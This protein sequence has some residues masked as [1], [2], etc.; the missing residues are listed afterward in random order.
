MSSAP[1][2]FLA[3]LRRNL[4]LVTALAIAVLYAAVAGPLH[5]RIELT[6]VVFAPL[7][8]LLAG[9][10]L[11]RLRFD[12]VTTAIYLGGLILYFF[13]LGY[14]TP[15]ERNYD[16]PEQI[17]YLK[18]IAEKHAIPPA[19]HC[20]IC[21]HPPFYY[22]L[23]AFAYQFFLTTKLAPHPLGIQ[24]FSLAIF[25][26]F[27]VYGGLFVRLYARDRRVVRIATALLV[28]WPYSIHNSVR[29]HNDTL[30]AALVAAGMYYAGRWYKGERPRH[31]YLAALCG[32]LGILTKSTAYVLVAA[33]GLMLVWKFFTRPG[34][35]RL[36]RRGVTAM[37]LVFAAMGALAL[38]AP[39]G[40][41]RC[42][43]TLGT[44]CD[45]RPRDFVGNGPV[46]YLYVDVRKL[47]RDPYMVIANDESGRQYFWNHVLKSSLFG[48][49]NK[50]PDRET[51]YQLN[52][53]LGWWL[54]VSLFA[55]LVYAAVA[56]VLGARRGLRHHGVPLLFVVLSSAFLMAFRVIIPAPHHTDFRHIFFAIVPGVLLFAA[57]VDHLRARHKAL[58]AVGYVLFAPFV[59]LSILYFVPKYDLVMKYTHTTIDVSLASV[60]KIVNEG[61]SW[62]K[63][64]NLLIEG[65]QTI[66]L[67]VDRPVT[68]T[69][70]ETS[71]DG[72]DSY[73]LKLFG[74]GPPRVMVVRPKK[75]IKPGLVRHALKVEPP[76]PDV[77]RITVRP[78]G[79]DRT[80]ALGHLLLNQ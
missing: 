5:L 43:R 28:F 14:T 62:D 59:A 75:N 72:N 67:I 38:R 79:G 40:Q 24:L 37:A 68:V 3:A 17:N 4:V 47:L 64:G 51:A 1:A 10:L 55:M 32:A 50:I 26:A 27:L 71:L 65:N 33:I 21:H 69:S 52:R 61:T 74:K 60:R 35:V 54:N 20:F 31:L 15:G 6:L 36:L 19:K 58:G 34:R 78:V 46:N 80:Y 76:V 13:Y 29:V 30:V 7:S 48:T 22:V 42:H 11:R 39:V 9:L 8:L 45:I 70:I 63:D 66:A 23:G 57:G 25:F 44:A 18:Y 53:S 73:E 49:H 2:R 56:G 77:T 16:G 41:D 12:R